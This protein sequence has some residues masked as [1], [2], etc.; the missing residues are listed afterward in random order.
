MLFKLKFQKL[1]SHSLYHKVKTNI[2]VDKGHIKKIVENL[3]NTVTYT[4]ILKENFINLDEYDAN[5]ITACYNTL[6]YFY[7]LNDLILP[8]S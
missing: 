3:M 7:Y 8:S 5:L 6:E 4:K 1:Y 2:I